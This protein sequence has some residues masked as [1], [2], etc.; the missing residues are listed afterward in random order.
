VPEAVKYDSD[1]DGPP[2]VYTLVIRG[3]KGNSN[4]T[5]TVDLC[6]TMQHI[7]DEYCQSTYE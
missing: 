4:L 6:K 5:Y 2:H 7:L 3:R 1:S